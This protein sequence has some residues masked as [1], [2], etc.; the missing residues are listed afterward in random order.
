MLN[1]EIM[2]FVRIFWKNYIQEA[3]LPKTSI[4]GQMFSEILA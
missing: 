4:V 2:E 3:N 1:L